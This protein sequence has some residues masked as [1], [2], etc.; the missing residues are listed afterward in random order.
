MKVKDIITSPG[1]R[2]THTVGESL[3]LKMIVELVLVAAGV[4]V[5]I[6]F[7]NRGE[8][9]MYGLQYLQIFAGFVIVATWI[10]TGN[11]GVTIGQ[12]FATVLRHAIYF[13]SGIYASLSFYRLF[14]HPLKSFPGPMMFKLS[15]LSFSGGLLGLDAH[16][17]I[18]SLHQKYGEF[19]RV[20]SSDLSIAH[21][22]AP[23]AI[24]GRKSRCLKS[25]WY[26]LTLPMTSMQTTQRR[27]EHDARRKVWGAAFND[28]ILKE[29][30]ARIKVYQDQLIG[31]VVQSTGHPINV[32]ELYH[33]FGFDVMGD[34]SFGESFDMLKSSGNH[35]AI[36]LLRRGM[37]P[38]GLMFPTWCFRLLLSVP[39]AT[40]D[41]FAFKNYCCDLVKKR[42]TVGNIM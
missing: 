8:H 33:Q 3:P 15:S 40:G 4:G 24:Y 28:T 6:G 22:H 41:W 38:L 34:L 7:F 1:L 11:A 9:H 16:K 10:H 27:A 23:E 35:W 2:P 19:V 25:E 17:Q 31:R 26:D 30:E 18:L 14:S 13:L 36:K 32:T 20:G 39:G 42:L 12:A 37:A 29:Y 5:H 21:P